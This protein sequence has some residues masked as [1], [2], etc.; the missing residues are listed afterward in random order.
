MMQLPSLPL[1]G[2][3]VLELGHSLSAP[4]AA[5][6]LAQLGAEV[7]KVETAAGD[8]ARDWGTASHGGS[9]VMFHAISAGKRSVTADLR[10]PEAVA[11]L[12]DLIRDRVDVIV[13]NMKAGAVERAGLDART[14]R[15]EKPTL[16]YCNISAFGGSG[17]LA[18]APGY[19]PLVQAVSGM[20]S[21]IGHPGDAPARVPVSLNDMGSGMWSVIGI[22]GALMELRRTGQG[23]TIDT[24]LYETALAWVTV[25]VS[26]FLASG[27]QPQRQGSGNANIVPYQDFP[28]ADGSLL[29]AAGNDRL[30][31][32]FCKVIGLP[33]LAEDPC[34]ATNS[35]RIANR[36]DLIARLSERT[37]DFATE[38]LLSKLA[39][40][41]VPA[42]PINSIETAATAPQ[43]AAI[44]IL[45]PTP[46]DGVRIVGLPLSINGQ[47][48]PIAGRSPR[49]GEHDHL[50]EERR[51]RKH[52]LARS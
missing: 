16:I 34:F 41:G 50:L 11:S 35:A 43:T 40:A 8:Y 12:R 22:L 4:Y 47:R 26:D 30:F 20:M 28:C 5:H 37:S 48:P 17:P 9:A 7:I 19:D 13:Q 39:E 52:V 10:D 32:G 31:R 1:A 25:Q 33:D 49:L 46:E 36:A 38:D 27:V 29:I 51:E 14:L 23:A 42:G 44:G 24:S 21:L 15:T 3:T 45:Q 2:I 18:G 6:I